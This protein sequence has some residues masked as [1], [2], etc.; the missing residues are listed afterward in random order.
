M[1]PNIQKDLNEIWICINVDVELESRTVV[2][3]V[4]PEDISPKFLGDNHE[5]MGSTDVGIVWKSCDKI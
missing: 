2:S 1:N 5:Q 4:P 3:N